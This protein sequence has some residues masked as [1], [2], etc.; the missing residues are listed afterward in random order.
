[1]GRHCRRA[2][3]R[4]DAAWSRPRGSCADALTGRHCRHVRSRRRGTWISPCRGPCAVAPTDRQCRVRSRRHETWISPCRESYVIAKP[5]TCLSHLRDSGVNGELQQGLPCHPGRRPSRRRSRHRRPRALW[6]PRPSHPPACRAHQ[7]EPMNL[8]RVVRNR[9]LLKHRPQKR[10]NNRN[11]L[12]ASSCCPPPA[13]LAAHR[14]GGGG[15][16]ATP[17][18]V[19]NVRDRTSAIAIAAA[20]RPVRSALSRS[21]MAASLV[22]DRGRRCLPYPRRCR[23]TSGRWTVTKPSIM[24]ARVQ[25]LSRVPS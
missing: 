7:A 25:G 2:R 4:Q 1:M 9:R 14:G 18:R 22:A 15:D 3:S 10:R 19:S 17:L 23:R 24:P 20:I 8:S 11:L 12:A 6:W 5:V 16:R 13:G 21:C